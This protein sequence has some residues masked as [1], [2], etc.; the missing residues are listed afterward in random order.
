[1]KT[2]RS[3]NA[4]GGHL[5]DFTAILDVCLVPQTKFQL[6][7]ETGMSMRHLHFCLKYLLKQN[8]VKYHHRKRTYVTTEEGLRLWQQLPHD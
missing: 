8:L 2:L 1:V 6:L 3:L 7:K 4:H 5:Q